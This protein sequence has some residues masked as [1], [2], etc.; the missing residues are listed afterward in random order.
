MFDALMFPY[1]SY[2]WHRNNIRLDATGEFIRAFQ[3]GSLMLKDYSERENGVYHCIAVN[4]YG[5]DVS[6]KFYIVAELRPY[7]DEGTQ[8]KF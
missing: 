5:T 6:V 3:N 8:G 2:T 1:L 4:E 7:Q